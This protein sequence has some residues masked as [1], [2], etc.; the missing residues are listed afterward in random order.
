MITFSGAECSP[1]SRAPTAGGQY[2]W[3]YLLAPDSSKKF[4]S[5]VT[6]ECIFRVLRVLA[7]TYSA[8]WQS[9]IAWQAAVASSIYLT[10]TAIQGLVILNYPNLEL[11][12]YH[13]TLITYAVLLV[14]V[15][16]NTYLGSHL[17][18]VEAVIL[19]LHIFGFFIVLIPLV[20]LGPHS[21]P[22]DVFAQFSS[23]AGYEN[24]GLSFFVGLLTAVYPF[25]GR[26][27][28]LL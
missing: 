9:T 2:H 19:F 10:G 18:L 11:Q 14:A 1:V 15:L 3:I 13:G 4:L 5:Y 23:S 20:Y 24:L 12:R 28:D 25:I 17:P 6:G 21:S 16:F 27:L 26:L 8:G 7:L 22:H